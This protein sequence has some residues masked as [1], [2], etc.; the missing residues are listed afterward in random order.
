ML[1]Q[2]TAVEMAAFLRA[3]Y[4]EAVRHVREDRCRF[5]RLDGLN[6]SYCYGQWQAAERA[7]SLERHSIPAA[8]RVR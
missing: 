7:A 4:E 3:R 1:T 8:T 6:V 2:P 5:P